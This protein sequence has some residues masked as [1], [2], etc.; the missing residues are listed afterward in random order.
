MQILLTGVT[1][2]I[3]GGVL[4]RLLD[5]DHVKKIFVLIR[6][7]KDSSA[8]ERLEA[9]YSEILPPH[10]R[11]AALAK[12]QAISGNL[13]QPGLDLSKED[14]ET[15]VKN[16]TQILHI[17]AS[18]KFN[19][20]ME[21]LRA[22]NVNGTRRMLDLAREALK[23]GQFKRFD[24]CSTAYV[25]GDKPGHVNENDL[26]RDQAFS[27]NYERSKYETE[28]M[29]RSEAK[30]V[31]F[32]VYRPSIVVGQSNNGYT[33]HFRVL[34]WPIKMIA[35]GIVPVIPCTKKA[36]LDVVPSDYICNSIVALS[37]CDE[38][39]GETYHLTAGHGNEV[40][41]GNLLKDSM[42]LGTVAWRP[43]IPVW[44][45]RLIE[46]SPLRH[47]LGNKFWAMAEKAAPYTRYIVGTGVTYDA[48]KTHA[49]L[50]KLGVQIPK[51]N[52]YKHRIFA[53]AQATAW[54]KK[55]IRPDYYFLDSDAT[56]VDLEAIVY[57]NSNETSS[58]RKLQAAKG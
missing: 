8:Q 12:T 39:I 40:T 52:D 7:G 16:V 15:L 23:N 21:E 49:M 46:H 20:P 42:K 33:P 24:Y 22:Y 53:Y 27:N 10:K 31:P 38:T 6:P 2:L 51:W 34:Y 54:G 29:I 3:G 45:F 5:Q 41:V 4:T 26:H 37:Q 14:R 11:T 28:T 35:N 47:L 50:A 30:E 18:T 32:S 19:A 55:S 57:P 25:A 43:M 13:T 17:A 58:I 48:S 44:I 1:G 36:T 56:P 9:L